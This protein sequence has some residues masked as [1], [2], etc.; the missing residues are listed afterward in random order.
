MIKENVKTTTKCLQYDVTMT[1][2]KTRVE[3]LA[4]KMDGLR[5]KKPK[6]MNLQRVGWKT[7]LK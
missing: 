2:V 3:S 4:Q 7:K 1:L 5:P 6:T